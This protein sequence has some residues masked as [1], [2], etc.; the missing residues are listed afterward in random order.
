[1]PGLMLA[2]R[3]SDFHTFL[4]LMGEVDE[5]PARGESAEMFRAGNGSS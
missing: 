2:I 1:M 5:V 3:R 4:A